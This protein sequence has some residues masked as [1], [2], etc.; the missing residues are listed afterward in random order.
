MKKIVICTLIWVFIS[1]TYSPAQEQRPPRQISTR[2]PENNDNTLR[3]L[4]P[5]EI[6]PNLNFYAI[7]PLYDPDAKLGWA[8]QRIE[9]QIDR[10]LTGTV[11]AD[12]NVYLSWRLLASDD[13]EIAFN[14]FRMDKKKKEKQLNDRPISLTT[15]FIDKIKVNSKTVYVLKESKN[16]QKLAEV[17]VDPAKSNPQYRSIPLKDVEGVDRIA[18]GDLNGDGVYDFVV[19]HPRQSVD[20][21]RVRPSNNSYKID[22]YDGKTGDFMWRIDLGWNINQGIWFS[23]MV[24]RDLDGD[25][26]AEVCVKTAPYA[27]TQEEAIDGGKGFVIEGPEYLSIY[28]GE[29]GKELD[30]V[31]WIERGTVQEWGD[32]SG[33]RSLRHMLGVA[34][35]DGK[36][37]SVLVVR[38][39]Y[40]M[41]KIDAWSFENKKLRKIWRWTNERAP[42]MYQ[43]QGQHSI[44]TGDIDGDGCDEILNGSIAIDNNGKTMWCTG[45]GHGDRFYLSDINPDHPGLE[46]WYIIEEPH[47]QLGA[48]LRDAKTGD[49]LFGVREATNDNEMSRAIVGD[50]DPAFPGMEVAGERF[51]FTADGKR[52]DQEAPPQDFLVWWDGDKLREILFRGTVS[53]W[54]GE[55]YLQD[56]GRGVQLIADIAGD[57][58]EEIVTFTDGEL[59]IYQTTIP[60]KDRRI[61]LMQDPL[62]RNDVTH[63]SMGY[64]HSPMTSYYLGE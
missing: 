55:T 10:G 24:V 13:D 21:G 26:K 19:K 39:I 16:N 8:E 1:I 44:K 6:P 2:P 54:K 43:G 61:C 32:N 18:V 22:A 17:T 51:Y 30:K 45:L 48:N 58:R 42:F 15:D 47:P 50:I 52:I 31:D 40:G 29:T 59:Q 46:V 38:G 36:T 34:Y 60:A 27:A 41:M 23:P 49:L 64:S 63:R 14:I 53:K 35:L 3:E 37:P 20:P 12:G 56:L 7:D 9:E 5:E 4:T 62:Y 11:L 28:D 33:N 57:W 25:N